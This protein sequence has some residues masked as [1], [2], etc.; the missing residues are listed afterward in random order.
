LCA[1]DAS[2][3]AGL[4]E[5]LTQVAVARTPL[6]LLAYD[7]Q[8]PEPLNAKRPIPDAFGVALVLAPNASAATLA[9]LTAMLTDSDADRMSEPRLEEMRASIPAAR[10]LPLLHKLAR[11]ESGR[12]TLDYL[13]HV[14]LALEVEP[15]S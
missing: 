10:S 14:R 11:R 12:V 9:K 4:L 8:Y 2:F 15:C 5:A 1:H 3:G 7:T 13:R 6:L